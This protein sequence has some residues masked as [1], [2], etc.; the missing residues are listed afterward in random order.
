MKSGQKMLTDIQ[1]TEKETE[2]ALNHMKRCST[3]LM[4]EM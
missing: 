1:F 3:S 2:T 4:R